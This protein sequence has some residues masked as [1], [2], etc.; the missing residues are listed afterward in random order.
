MTGWLSSVTVAEVIG[1]LIALG[2][3]IGGLKWIVPVLRNL[4]D[5]LEDWRGEPAR[6][7]KDARPG[8]PERMQS[9]EQTQANLSEAVGAVR[10]Q[11]ENSHSINLRDDLDEHKTAISELHDSVDRLHLRLDESAEDRKGLHLTDTEIA[12][13]L[14][15][16]EVALLPPLDPES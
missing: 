13:R 8:I 4:R 9:I 1:S 12:A 15:R 2:V 3:L 11:V 5:F 16:L 10:K 14:A 6:P 7:G